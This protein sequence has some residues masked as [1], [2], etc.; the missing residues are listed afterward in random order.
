MC[1]V[2]SALHLWYSVSMLL[3]LN[4]ILDFVVIAA[5][6]MFITEILGTF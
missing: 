1:C 5:A 2:S 6:V 4:F 3:Y